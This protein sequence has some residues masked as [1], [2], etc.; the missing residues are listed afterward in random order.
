MAA[1]SC[2]PSLPTDVLYLKNNWTS[3][4]WRG[5]NSL[6]L[7]EN[8]LF[9]ELISLIIRV[10]KCLK[11]GCYPAI[12]DFAFDSHSK[13]QRASGRVQPHYSPKY[14]SAIWMPSSYMLWN[15]PWN[16]SPRLVLREKNSMTCAIGI[17]RRRSSA[18]ICSSTPNQSTRRDHSRRRNSRALR[19]RRRARVHCGCGASPPGCPWVQCGHNTTGDPRA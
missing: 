16:C 8:S 5:P 12:C 4:L 13:F 10:G 11:S 7:T 18:S 6:L 19:R 14:F 15:F 1:Q 9:L 3:R 2:R 17:S